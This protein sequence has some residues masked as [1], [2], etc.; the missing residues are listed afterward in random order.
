MSTEFTPDESFTFTTPEG[1]MFAGWNTFSAYTDD[2]G[3]TSVLS[4]IVYSPH[5]G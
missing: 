4:F 3:C 2:D 1:H 5:S